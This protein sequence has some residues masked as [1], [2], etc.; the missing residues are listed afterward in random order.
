VS[1]CGVRRDGDTNQYAE[2]GSLHS[3]QIQKG[4]LGE[5]GILNAAE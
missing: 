4:H 2:A 1:V 3:R 5:G